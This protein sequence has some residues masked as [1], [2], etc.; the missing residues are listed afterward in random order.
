MNFLK[1]KLT[2]LTLV[3]VLIGLLGGGLYYYA[4]PKIIESRAK[5]LN[6]M[7]FDSKK[8]KF[9]AKDSIKISG[10]DLYY[11]QHGNVDGY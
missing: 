11:L 6:L 7:R 9:V 10:W 3:V 4:L 1:T 8:D 2:A 5:D